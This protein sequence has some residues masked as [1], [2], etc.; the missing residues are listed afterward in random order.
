MSPAV[1]REDWMDVEDH[2]S[3]DE[4][5]ARRK[6]AAPPSS[7]SPTTSTFDIKRRRPAEEQEIQ[8][9][10]NEHTS[11]ALCQAKLRDWTPE[12]HDALESL[13]TAE[14]TDVTRKGYGS[15]K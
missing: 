7:R 4:P 1:T 12:L 15:K 6:R 3:D 14:A 11:R 8:S 5:I 9:H 13:P 10:A 2:E